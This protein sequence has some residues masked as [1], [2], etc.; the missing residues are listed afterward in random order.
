MLEIRPFEK[1]S[2]S[3]SG[4]LATPFRNTSINT[5]PGMAETDIR[6]TLWANVLALM[7]DKYG[8]ENINRL[9][10]EAKLGVATVQRI[11]TARQYVRLNALEKIA[12][13]FRVEPWQLVSQEMADQKFLE[14][15]ALWRDTDSRG[16]RML[17]SALRGAQHEEEDADTDRGRAAF[18]K[19]QR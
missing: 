1:A 7:E 3:L 19:A 6:T 2:Y 4:I 10:R 14:V 12:K 15:L 16:R 11:K 8:K 5:I 18:R 13:H 9:A 17:L